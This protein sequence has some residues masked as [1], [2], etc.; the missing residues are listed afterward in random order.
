[1]PGPHAPIARIPVG[2][3]VERAFSAVKREVR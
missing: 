3:V 2:V 1:M